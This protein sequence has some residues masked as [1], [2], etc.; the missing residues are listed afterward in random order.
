VF[1]GTDANRQGTAQGVQLKALPLQNKVAAYVSRPGRLS[2]LC[3][4]SPDIS[5]AASDW[6]MI[7]LR[8]PGHSFAPPHLLVQ[9]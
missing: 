7:P 4:A 6:A 8:A 3:P 1:L 5:G 9:I 2:R